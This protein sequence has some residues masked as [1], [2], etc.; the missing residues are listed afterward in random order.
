MISNYHNLIQ[1][2]WEYNKGQPLGST[3]LLIYFYLLKLGHDQNSYSVSI[4]DIKVGKELGLTRKTVKVTKEKLQNSGVIKYV[5]KNGLA[6]TYTIIP[7]YLFQT[8]ESETKP[9]DTSIPKVHQ[10]RKR[11]KEIK[12]SDAVVHKIQNPECSIEKWAPETR[13]HK[14]KST[15]IPTLEQVYSYVKSLQMYDSSLDEPVKLKYLDWIN[16]GWKNNFN[17]PISDWKS[18][19][20][21]SLPYLQSSSKSNTILIPTIPTIKR[22][23][24]SSN[25]EE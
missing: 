22:I 3:A 6:C 8:L 7:D 1:R 20:K 16:N 5:T 2:F 4:S 14:R 15:P 11:Q 17:R 18:T 12:S 24:I 9:A 19:I 13:S 23:K 25:S 21:N 10:T